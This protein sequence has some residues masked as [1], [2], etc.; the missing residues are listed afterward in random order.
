MLVNGLSFGVSAVPG[1]HLLK[2]RR[3]RGCSVLARATYDELAVLAIGSESL[4]LESV[5]AVVISC[6][7][8]KKFGQL[9]RSSKFRIKKCYH[10]I[11]TSRDP[12]ITT[13]TTHLLL[14]Q[15]GR[16]DELKYSV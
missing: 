15:L 6:E 16:H 12:I 13:F 5:A 8:S 3:S 10:V 4:G 11:Q 1:G 2:N 7:V 9:L 14:L